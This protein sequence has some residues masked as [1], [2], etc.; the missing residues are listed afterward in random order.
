MLPALRQDLG[1]HPGPADASGAPTWTLHDPA[2]HRF[3]EISWPAFELISRWPLGSADAVLD[4]VARETTLRLGPQDLDGLL[5]FL[6]QHHLLQSHSAEHS[7]RLARAARAGRS[8][9]AMWLLKHYLFFRVPL[10][11][12]EPLLRAISPYTQWLFRPGFWWAMA[13][14]ALLGLFLVSRRWDEFTHTFSAYGSLAGLLGLGLA[15]SLAKLLH[16]LGHAITAHRYGCRVPAMG[17][18]FLV[19]WPVLYTDTNE[20]W[21]LIRRDQRL[22]IAAAGM[23]AELALAACATLSWSFL[24][25]G[26]L[27]A[28]AFMLATSSWL[29]TLGI[30]ASPFMR[31]DGYF[32][33]ADALNMPNLHER[34]FA[35][36]RWWLREQLYGFGDPVPEVLAPGRQRFLIAFAFATWLYRLVLFFGIALLVY[37]LFFKALGLLLMAVELGWFIALPIWRELRHWWQRR[38]QMRWNPRTRRSAALLVGLLLL[39]ALPWRS[40]V[41]APALLSHR[42]NQAL[43][44]VETAQQQGPAVAE[45]ANVEAGQLLLRLASP[46]LEQRLRLAQHQEALLRWQM[47]QQPLDQQLQQEGQALHRRWQAAREEVAGLQRQREQ[48]ELRSPFAGTVV[49]THPM[50]ADQAWFTRGEKLFQLVG[51]PDSLKV[52][53]FVSEGQLAA[54]R[55]HGVDRSRFVANLP[56][57][58]S[59]HC[60]ALQ[61]ES[62]NLRSLPQPYLASVYG[63]PISSV[64]QGAELRPLAATYRAR[65]TQCEPRPLRS[66]LAGR[67]WLQGESRSL[68]AEGWQRLLALWRQEAGL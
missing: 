68:L 7:D 46:E 40:G 60:G 16:E 55:Q 3:Y 56:E 11:R 5:S 15:L 54:L 22:R 58:G 19:M 41:Q 27:R 39:L 66:E 30:N 48:L 18:A 43:Y 44:A 1:L 14:A 8:S 53:A 13:G 33:L 35:Q 37:H 38:Q 23:L 2:A 63:G 67:V 12:P 25:D 24:P 59:L 47:E 62:V 6:V 51:R 20:A 42:E 28:G 26:P 4:A 64:Q 50:L 21:K 49:A 52:E 29:I 17:V 34:A 61:L 32:L 45:G 65:L 31:F 36:G 9:H 57:F 10:L